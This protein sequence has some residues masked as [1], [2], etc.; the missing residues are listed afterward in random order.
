M[1]LFVVMDKSILGRGVFAVFSSPEKAQSFS[2]DLYLNTRFRSEVKACSI[3]GETGASGTVWAAHTYDHF[4]DTHVFDGIYSD[5]N[6]A[7]DAVGKKG[8]I[9]RFIID[10]PE[11]REI[12][13]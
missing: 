2:E 11:D 7:Y 5:S 8:L 10:S 4:Y 1:E 3:I 13:A 12:I 9:I 6:L